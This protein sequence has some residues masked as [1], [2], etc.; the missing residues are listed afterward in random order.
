MKTK[1]A[2]IFLGCMIFGSQ[3]QAIDM[4]EHG[5]KANDNMGAFLATV[6]IASGSI[7]GCTVIGKGIKNSFTSFKALPDET[8]D[9]I[10]NYGCATLYAA[11]MANATFNTKNNS[12]DN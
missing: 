4:N 11:F 2:M 12:D 3:A 9:P 10:I 7:L 6:T 8:T 5:R 1:F